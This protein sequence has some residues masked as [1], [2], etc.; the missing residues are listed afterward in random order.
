LDKVLPLAHDLEEIHV[1]AESLLDQHQHLKEH[2]LEEQYEFGAQPMK[3]F[4]VQ[5]DLLGGD[6]SLIPH[7]GTT[8][9]L[10]LLCDNETTLQRT[11]LQLKE[12]H[13]SLYYTAEVLM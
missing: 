13:Q 12:V 7:F 11:L 4:Q 9:A 10:E 5:G 2:S 1:E 8:Q 6:S 3:D